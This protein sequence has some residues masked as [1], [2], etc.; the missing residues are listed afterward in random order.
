MQTITLSLDYAQNNNYLGDTMTDKRKIVKYDG[1]DFSPDFNKHPL[2]EF[3]DVDSTLTEFD[4]EP[5]EFDSPV[6]V[7][8]DDKDNDLDSELS[9]LS[10]LAKHT[11]E[12]QQRIAL[13]VEPKYRGELL[14]VANN[15]LNTALAAVSKK[16][17]MKKHKDTIHSRG[18]GVTI[19]NSENTNIIIADRNELL[20]MRKNK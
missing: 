15:M 4:D 14:A 3:F 9:E 19:G 13:T 8:Y 1:D 10:K 12:Q 11:F 5:E 7:L 17:D 16:V 18:K 20:K 2:D 6:S